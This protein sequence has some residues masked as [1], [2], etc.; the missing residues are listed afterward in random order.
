MHG[1]KLYLYI[2]KT[3][4]ETIKQKEAILELYAILKL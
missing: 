4:L 3:M 1:K 2:E